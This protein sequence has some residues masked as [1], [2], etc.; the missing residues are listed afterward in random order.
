M[1]HVL[2]DQA[3]RRRTTKRG[4]HDVRVP[5]DEAVTGAALAPRPRVNTWLAAVRRTSIGVDLYSQR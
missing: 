1:R 4:G 5:L 3:R 2:V